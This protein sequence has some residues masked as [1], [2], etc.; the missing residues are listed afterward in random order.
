[1]GTCPRCSYHG[2]SMPY[3]EK[4]SHV[5]LL[6]AATVVTLPAVLGAGGAVYYILRKN[7]RICP[8]CGLSW[9]KF[10]ELANAPAAPVPTETN[11]TEVPERMPPRGAEVTMRVWSVLLA[12]LATLFVVAGALESE[13]G[14][15]VVGLV[16]GAG[17]WGLRRGA[18]RARERRRNALLARLQTHVLKLARDREG[19]LTVTEVA[20]ALSW[21]MRRAEKVLHSLDDGWRVNSRVT[22]EGVIVYEFREL[23]KG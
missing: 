14:M 23:L 19:V 22:D 18:A 3:F 11:T 12:L 13:I 2:G 4:G 16:T 5:A 21:P 8:R 9:G 20:A 15:V 7:H 17:A 10:G 6:V 1:M